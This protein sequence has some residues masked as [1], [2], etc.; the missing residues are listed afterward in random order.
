MGPRQSR[1]GAGCHYQTLSVA[2]PTETASSGKTQLLQSR[3]ERGGRLAK[4]LTPHADQ[5][6]GFSCM[7]LPDQLTH[8]T[9]HAAGQRQKLLSGE[10]SSHTA[11]SGSGVILTELP[12]QFGF[13]CGRRQVGV[14]QLPEQQGRRRRQLALVFSFSAALL[15]LRGAEFPIVFALSSLHSDRWGLSYTLQQ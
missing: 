12:L 7:L 11:A 1:R 15:L 5:V 14:T 2:G 8:S 10:D 13:S 4:G 6:I 9:M 3:S